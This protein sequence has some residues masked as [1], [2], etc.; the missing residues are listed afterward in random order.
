M[1]C[2]ESKARKEPNRTSN[3]PFASGARDDP[4]Y[5]DEQ[6]EPRVTPASAAFVQAAIEDGDPLATYLL[7]QWSAVQ[8]KEALIRQ[9]RLAGGGNNASVSRGTSRAPSEAPPSVMLREDGTNTSASG[10]ATVGGPAAW[11]NTDLD[12]P[13]SHANAQH[14]AQLFCQHVLMD[15][16]HR[17]WR[18]RANFDVTGHPADG[19]V[20]IVITIERPSATTASAASSHPTC[21]SDATPTTY[22]I[23][24]YYHAV[25]S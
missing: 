21:T 24:A 19:I 2:G 16:V 20:Q 10:G 12:D 3:T 22:T 13:L 4:E 17:G 14:T 7:D 1:G 8:G 15:M 6:G 23:E 9:R 18:G 11:V 5:F 25:M